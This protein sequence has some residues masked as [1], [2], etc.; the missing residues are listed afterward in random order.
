MSQH[1]VDVCYDKHESTV[2]SFYILYYCPIYHD[3]YK[4]SSIQD[5]A[6]MYSSTR[7]DML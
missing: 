7:F 2:A 4:R 6:M 1:E 5:L 3:I